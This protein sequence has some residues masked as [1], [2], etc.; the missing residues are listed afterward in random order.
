MECTGITYSNGRKEI[1]YWLQYLSK[2][3]DISVYKYIDLSELEVKR[4]RDAT[5][6]NL[7]EVLNEIF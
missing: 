5:T 7:Q 3:R 2:S 6:E 4:I 1:Q